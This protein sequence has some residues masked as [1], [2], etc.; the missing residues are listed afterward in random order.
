MFNAVFNT[1]IKNGDDNNTHLNF[2][3]DFSQKVY[4]THIY[5]R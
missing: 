2:L 3:F 5:L 1:Q 4:H